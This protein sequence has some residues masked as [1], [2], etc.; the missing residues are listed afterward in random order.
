MKKKEYMAPE[1]SVVVM[2]C[3]KS[4]LIGSDTNP[5]FNYDDPG[6]GE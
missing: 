3:K 2:N 1:L 5:D 6:P 4:L